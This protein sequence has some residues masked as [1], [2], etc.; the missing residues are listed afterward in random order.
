MHGC[1]YKISH[2]HHCYVLD[3]RTAIS[4]SPC[5]SSAYYVAAGVH[6]PQV[7]D[8]FPLRG[9]LPRTCLIYHEQEEDFVFFLRS[10]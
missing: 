3:P 7:L 6:P 9:P 1:S 4:V 2:F 5:E 8:D 10:V